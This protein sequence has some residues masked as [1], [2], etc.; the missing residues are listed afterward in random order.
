[1]KYAFFLGCTIPARA[2]NYE[3]S[4]RKVAEKL[5]IELVDI[6]RFM[7]CGFPIKAADMDASGL[8]A[9]YNLSLARE[10]NLDICALCSSCT[11]AL[12]EA[13]HHLS[14]DE[15]E[16]ARVNKRL[17]A[18]GLKYTSSP[19]VRHFARILFEE[20]GPEKIT[21][22]FQ[23]DLS[24][25]T[26]AVHYGCHYLKP[27]KIHDHFDDVEDPKSI[28]ALVALTGARVVDYTGKKK[29]CGGPVLPVDERLAL[30]VTREKL[31]AIKD[32]GADALCLV[33]PFCSVMYDGN[34]KSIESEFGT[35][36]NL[37]VL[38]LTQVLG[39]AMGFDRKELGLNINVVK[40]KEL[41]ERYFE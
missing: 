37:P 14:W 20:V 8:L 10:E 19:R 3:L 38:Y 35:D 5:G 13:A 16:K 21:A 29:C 12:G 25:L 41:L 31:E 15:D 6:E 24:D 30:S 9:A 23:K 34:Q 18:V 27:S 32:S 7:C 11:S 28:D 1:M 36:Y 33:C 39:L 4:A 17:S 22:H 40:T 26:I 2:R